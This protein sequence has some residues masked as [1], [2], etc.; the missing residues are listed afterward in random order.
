MKKY[1]AIILSILCSLSVAGCAKQSVGA[2][3]NV[4]FEATILEIGENYYLVE[5]VEG[6]QELHS[7][8]QIEVP[9]KNLDPSLEPEVGDIIEIKHSG[10]ILETFPARLSEVYGIKVTKESEK[11][12]LISPV[13]SNS[14]EIITYNG[15]EYKKSELSDATLK[16]LELSKEDRMLS[17]Y[18][19]PEFMVIDENWGVTLKA[20]NITANGLTLVCTQTGGEATGSLQTGSWY[21]IEKWT[22]ATGWTEVDYVS[23]EYDITWTQEAYM[24]PKEEKIEW[25]VNWEWLYGKL[26]TGK[27]RIGKEIMDFREA[28]NYDSAIYYAE[29]EIT[30]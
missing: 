8:D 4:T 20:E 25:E 11:T 7:A 9:M 26:P 10:E 24:I 2:P 27:Y 5:P 18:F 12:E 13:E 16:W 22:Q 15:K 29:F 21:I 1:I 14:D 6:S 30:E 23:Q 19:P 28:G 3:P 17:S